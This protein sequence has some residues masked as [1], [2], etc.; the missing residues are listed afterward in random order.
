MALL[1]TCSVN[2]SLGTE[3][4]SGLFYAKLKEKLPTSSVVETSGKKE[5]EEEDLGRPWQQV[6]ILH[7]KLAIAYHGSPSPACAY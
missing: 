2:P 4:V 5:E 6:H 7:N 3:P 1:L